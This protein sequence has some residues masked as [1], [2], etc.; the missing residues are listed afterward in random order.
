MAVI[1][2]IAIVAGIAALGTAAA[3]ALVLATDL[4]KE[5]GL[6]TM[7][8]SEKNTRPSCVLEN[9]RGTTNDLASRAA[10]V[11]EWKR[12]HLGCQFC[13]DIPAGNDVATLSEI[14]R[15]LLRHRR[16]RERLAAII[17]SM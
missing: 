7:S 12:A 3:L 10:R 8:K 17:A 13:K 2:T 16:A 15:P 9:L 1:K 14:I 6:G 5:G 11:V 4:P